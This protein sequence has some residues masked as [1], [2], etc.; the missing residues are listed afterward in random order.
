[1]KETG[2]I[3]NREERKGKEGM[4]NVMKTWSSS[5]H[6][7]TNDRE[8]QCEVPIGMD[9]QKRRIQKRRTIQRGVRQTTEEEGQRRMLHIDYIL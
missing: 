3:W 7:E 9:V 2:L 6:V 4:K 1:L 8:M 5:G